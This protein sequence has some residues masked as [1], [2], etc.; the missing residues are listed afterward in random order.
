MC[1]TAPQKIITI[2][3]DLATVLNLNN[4]RERKINI[5][6][7]KNPKINDWLLVNANLAIK[8]ISKQEAKKI[9]QII[10]TAQSKRVYE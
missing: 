2:S 8:K 5:S 7:I 6:L 9:I 3:G 1:I 4:K 10:K